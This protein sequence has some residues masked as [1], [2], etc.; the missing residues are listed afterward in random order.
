MKQ[1]TTTTANGAA[2][3][4][5][6]I[7]RSADSYD[8]FTNKAVQSMFTEK[9]PHLEVDLTM[10][11]D[12][13]A[14]KNVF[15][16][17]AAKVARYFVESRPVVGDEETIFSS[18]PEPTTA[19]ATTQ[20]MDM[21]AAVQSRARQ[22]A[23]LAKAHASAKR[24]NDL[25][26]ARTVLM[27]RLVMHFLLDHTQRFAAVFNTYRKHV[28]EGRLSYDERE[29]KPVIVDF[30]KR[31]WQ[32]AGELYNTTVVPNTRDK[33]YKHFSSR[34]DP[35]NQ[36]EIKV[37]EKKIDF[38]FRDIDMLNLDAA[39]LNAPRFPRD[40]TQFTFL[41]KPTA[42]VAPA[43]VSAPAPAIVP[44]A[45]SSPP[46]RKRSFESV[47]AG[48]EKSWNADMDRFFHFETAAAAAAAAASSAKRTKLE[49]STTSVFDLLEPELEMDWVE[50]DV[51]V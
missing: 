24:H 5:L 41:V 14:H 11:S 29:D 33:Y 26:M 8:H 18:S 21:F 34:Y 13:P 7:T 47:A 44:P 48:V 40:R 25:I 38:V 10:L 20:Q 46:S 36:A 23:I 22:Y 9:L 28:A 39:F 6:C 35:G 31:M 27:K 43:A 49:V 32:I 42:A 3:Q 50:M 16:F 2:K 45:P 30:M 37:M 15:V 12:N 4:C 17:C 51:C 19:T 1:T